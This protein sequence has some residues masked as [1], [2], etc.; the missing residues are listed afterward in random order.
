MM[1][2][3]IFLIIISLMTMLVIGVS[4]LIYF[5]LKLADRSNDVILD[6]EPLVDSSAR[7]EIERLRSQIDGYDRRLDGLVE[8]IQQL[9]HRAIAIEPHN[10]STILTNPMTNEVPNKIINSYSKVVL[11]AN[12]R[13]L[14][15]GLRIASPSYLESVLGR[16]RKLLSDKCEEMT[17]NRLRD[18]LVLETVG[19][20]RVQM[21]HP[22]VASLKRVFVR[23]KAAD[24]D[25]YARIHTAGS[26]CVRQIRGTDQRTSSH[27]FGLAVDLNIDGQLDI[28]G[29][30]KTQLGLTILADFFRDEGWYWGAGFTREDSMHFEVSRNQIERWIKDGLL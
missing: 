21:L 17:N 27:S 14:N 29:D 18:R 9:E 22:A 15:V 2:K 1:Q 26:L 6:E 10:S 8:R 24:P 23:I 30:G 7:I 19:P 16:P 5:Q 28:L 3:H 13:Q 11:I 20:I 12:R 25:L 4:C